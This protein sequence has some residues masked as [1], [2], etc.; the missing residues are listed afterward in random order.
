M[1]SESDNA[2]VCQKVQTV[3]FAALGRV[4]G[5][6]AASQAGRVDAIAGAA[7]RSSQ[8]DAM[9]LVRIENSSFLVFSGRPDGTSA[10]HSVY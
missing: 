3:S 4:A 1:R 5:V 9:T 7:R 8:R 10:I 2:M 6:G